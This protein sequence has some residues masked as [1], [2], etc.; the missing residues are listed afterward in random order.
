M[1]QLCAQCVADGVSKCL[2]Q[3]CH[4]TEEAEVGLHDQAESVPVAVAAGT[5]LAG[6]LPPVLGSSMLQDRAV[7][8]Q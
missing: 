2:K 7:D 3:C 8:V 5:Q 1:L 6:A 4:L